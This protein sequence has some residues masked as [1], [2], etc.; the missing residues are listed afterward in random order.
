MIREIFDTWLEDPELFCMDVLNRSLW[1]K[2]VEMLESLRDN[3]ETHAPADNS[4]GK[5][6]VSAIAVLY[7]LLRGRSKV[8][9]TA[10]T[11]GN[12]GVFRSYAFYLSLP[13]RGPDNLQY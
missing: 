6:E 10:P 1:S 12:S 3:V 4:V 11:F 7:V 13:P 8:V 2:Q 5:T 9:I